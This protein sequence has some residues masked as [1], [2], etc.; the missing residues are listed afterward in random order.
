MMKSKLQLKTH[1][2]AT[3]LDHTLVGQP[4]ELNELLRLLDSFSNQIALVYVT[5]RHASSTLELMKEHNLPTPDLLIS[6]V[7]TK[8]WHMPDWQE[9]AEWKKRTKTN[10]YPDRIAQCASQVDGL[11][12][13]SLPDNRRVSYTVENDA[14]AV[15]RFES[16]LAN[17]HIPHRLIYSSSRDVDVLPA[18]AGKGLA[19]DY[20][21]KHLAAPDVQLLVAG[22]SGNDI[23]MLTRGWPSVIVGNAQ[24]ELK[25]IP[26][27]PTIFR[28]DRA[29]AGGIFDGLRHFYSDVFFKST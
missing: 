7:G 27:S 19:L 17:V 25:Q 10:W 8:I 24:A 18:G 20:V 22:D 11:F 26:H 6:D 2:L 28:A 9:D 16:S 3:D 29:C 15:R 14:K 12:A 4:S 5:G 23:D 13:Q 1:L 21:V